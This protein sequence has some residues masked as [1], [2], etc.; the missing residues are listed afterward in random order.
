[1]QIAAATTLIF[2]MTIKCKTF[3]VAYNH[4]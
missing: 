2:W 1:M 4:S 3:L